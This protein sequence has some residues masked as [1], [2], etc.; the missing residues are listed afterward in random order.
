MINLLKFRKQTPDGSM[1]G[2]ESYMKYSEIVFKMV[3]ERGGRIV[4]SGQ[5]VPE[6]GLVIGDDE[7]DF[8]IIVQYP[9]KEAFLDMVIDNPEY[10]AAHHF[11]D[12]GLE[13]TALIPTYPKI[14]GA[15]L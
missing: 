5:V 12:A 8:V 2:M 13:A 10:E 4:W 14:L 7:W 6:V 9:S 3:K 11:R 15:K 1:S